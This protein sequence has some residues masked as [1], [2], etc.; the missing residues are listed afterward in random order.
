MDEVMEYIKRL[1][2]GMTII[3]PD[4]KIPPWGPPEP[5]H[6]VW[7]ENPI[8]PSKP[9]VPVWPEYTTRP[10]RTTRPRRTRRPTQRPGTGT[11]RPSP[12]GPASGEYKE[13]LDD[14]LRHTNIY[15]QK[16]HSPPVTWNAEIARKAQAYAEVLARSY[17]QRLV[18]D[19]DHT[20]GENLG[21]ATPNIAK[22]IVHNWYNEVRYYDYNKATFSS[23]T[24]HFTAL[25]W[26]ETT[27]MGCG[28]AMG[29]SMI[30]VSCKY[31]PPGN[32]MGDFRENVLRP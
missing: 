15:R 14:I 18:H 26:K 23:G 5:P 29:Q 32:M 25:V 2:P 21:A 30:F 16:H 20:Y 7:P 10:S 13:L 31:S 17:D 1:Y 8:R 19:S 27:E 12:G 3:D 28:A 6:P 24:G 11:R 4:Q 22:N 9:T